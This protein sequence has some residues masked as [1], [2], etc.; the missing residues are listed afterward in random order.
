MKKIPMIE[1]SQKLVGRKYKL[2][3]MDCFSLILEYMKLVGMEVPK[4]Y[5]GLTRKTYKKLFEG[6]HKEAKKIMVQ[7]M[8]DHFGKRSK[9][10]YKTGDVLLLALQGSKEMPFLAIAAGNGNIIAAAEKYGVRVT[11]IKY[12]KVRRA[13]QC[14]K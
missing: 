13:F 9:Y 8:E 4:E 1:I 14:H 2:G 10:K 6:D 5:N 11:P 12:Y 7:F 3:S